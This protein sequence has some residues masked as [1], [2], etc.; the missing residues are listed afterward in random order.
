MKAGARGCLDLPPP[1]PSLPFA[2]LTLLYLHLFN[3]FIVREKGEERRRRE[4]GRFDTYG[5]GMCSEGSMT[6]LR[7]PQR[8]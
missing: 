2:S 6:R 1:A 5:D 4:D 3:F 7:D 8:I